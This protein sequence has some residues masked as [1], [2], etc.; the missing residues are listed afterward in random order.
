M[1]IYNAGPVTLTIT[2]GQTASTA[3][4]DT[5]TEGQTKVTMGALVSLTI[6]AP[7]AL[8]G[9]ITIQ[10]KPYPA[11]SSWSTLQSGGT[12]IG[13]AAGKAVNINNIPFG[14]IRILSGSAEGAQRDFVIL[15][16]LT[17]N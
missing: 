7:S 11:A 6:F 2:S 4:S 9:S 3:L 1:S 14:D 17:S 16:Q 5:W 15:F 10:V 8:T 12:D 13:V